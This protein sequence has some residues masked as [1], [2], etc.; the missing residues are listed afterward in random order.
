MKIAI[1]AILFGRS[2][3]AIALPLGV[4]P[5][6]P[7]K[8]PID[9]TIGSARTTEALTE[10]TYNLGELT[11]FV[12]ALSES[13]S[14]SPD[15]VIAVAPKCKSELID[16]TTEITNIETA[17]IATRKAVKSVDKKPSKNDKS[18]LQRC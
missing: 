6:A 10:L 13:L 14:A 7:T 17:L 1:L 11:T 9:G 3:I 15:K 18:K 4:I 8:S 12:K 2:I 16:L 5:T